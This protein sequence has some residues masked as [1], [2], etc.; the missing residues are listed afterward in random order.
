VAHIDPNLARDFAVQVVER[1]RTGGHQAL[2]AGGCVRD[3]LMGQ[4]PKDY[5]VATDA[6]PDRVREL[7]GKRQTLAIGA[8]FG[9]IT[10]L[11]AREAG[12]IE[13]ATF[14][15]DAEYSDGRHPDSVAFSDAEHDAQRRDFTIN[16]LFF[17]PIAQQVID[18]VGGQADLEKGVIRA[19]GEA[20]ARLAE[21]KLRML[22]AV[23]FAARFDFEIEPVTLA[24][25]K[26]Q[27]REL[28]IVSAERIAAELRLILTHPSRAKGLELLAE[29]GLLEVL[30]PEAAALLE[31]HDAWSRCLAILAGMH[32]PTFTMALAAVLRELQPPPGGDRPADR[33]FRRWKLSND[34]LDSLRWLLGEESVIRTARA[35]SWPRLQRILAAPRS[36]ELVGYCEA[37]AR[38][39]DGST[40]QI[41]FCREKLALPAQDL[42]PLPLITGDDLKQLGIRPGPAYR[43]L[44]EAVRDAQLDGKIAARE[45]ALQLVQDLNAKPGA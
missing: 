34:E 17:D 31:S 44:L 15:R 41:D 24:A 18:Y 23:R 8:S 11:G 40:A 9:V 5:D 37:I 3:Q 29:T 36:A 32:A 30:L 12:H 33:V 7:F 22:R 28:V 39:E 16:G 25:I 4:M 45:D 2:W 42:N 20:R 35:Q 14:R 6:L 27:C 43:E 26:E 38:V 19:I 10:V 13:V 21:D 1:L